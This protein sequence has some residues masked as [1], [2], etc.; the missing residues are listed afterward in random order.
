MKLYADYSCIKAVKAVKAD[1]SLMKAA[2]KPKLNTCNL[3]KFKPSL[4][5]GLMNL[6]G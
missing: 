5:P 1:D 2:S 3:C 4:P 6:A